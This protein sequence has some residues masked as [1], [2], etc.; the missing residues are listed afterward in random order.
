M[1]ITKR[2]ID[3]AKA[4]LNQLLERA[5]DT[6]DPRRKLASIPDAELEAELARRKAA[7][8]G[9]DKVTAAR[10]RVDAGGST[11]AA[12]KMPADRAERERV[13]KER[14]A[15]VR[16]AREAR[17]KASRENAERAWKAQRPSGSARPDPRERARRRGGAKR[18][19]GR[20][21]DP[22]A[23]RYYDRLELPYDSDFEAVKARLPEAHAAVPTRTSTATRARTN[24]APPPRSPRP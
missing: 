8:L 16:A 12:P 20:G 17:E 24:S 2:I 11:G 22:D 10:A 21:Q 5:A 15:R 23:K 4:N 6:A 13:A 1:S 14:E 9:E 3:L 18:P 7:R 19:F